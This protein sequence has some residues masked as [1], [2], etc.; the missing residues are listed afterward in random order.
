MCAAKF[1]INSMWAN[2]PGHDGMRLQS[3]M[4]S[5]LAAYIEQ[6]LRREWMHNGHCN[7]WATSDQGTTDLFKQDSTVAAE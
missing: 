1:I 6:L 7:C 3:T 2:F 5:I 4:Y